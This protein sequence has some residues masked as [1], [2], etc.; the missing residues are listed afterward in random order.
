MTNTKRTTSAAVTK[1]QKPEQITS[2]I[3]MHT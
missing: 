1:T 3:L 2:E